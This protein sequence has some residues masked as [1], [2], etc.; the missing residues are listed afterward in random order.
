MD[1]FPVILIF[2]TFSR[3]I[4]YL[5]SCIILPNEEPLLSL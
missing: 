4:L 5:V 1:K 2:R 3:G